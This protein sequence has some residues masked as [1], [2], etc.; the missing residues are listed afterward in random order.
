M[1]F[2]HASV[3]SFESRRA[4]EIAELIR[5]Q[6]GEPFVAPALVE[7]P[8]EHNQNALDFAKRLYAGEF[9]AVIFLTGVGARLLHSVIAARDGEERFLN[10][11]RK[12]V[13]VCRGPKPAAVLREWKVP[14]TILVAEPAT[15]REV[16]TALETRPEK[17]VAIQEY[18]RANPSLVDGLKQQG[19]K[20]TCVAV[21]QWK[22]PDDT[23]LLAQALDGLLGGKFQASLFTTGVQVDHFLE[24]AARRGE[25]ERAVGALNRTFVASIGPDCSESLRACG[26]QPAFEPSHPKMGLLV[27]E[28]AQR[29]SERH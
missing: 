11:L 24:F 22:L 9:E 7:V 16:L 12:V 17:S 3:L 29:F 26:I 1:P 28:A 5:L 15:W 14:L 2:N 25:R 4:A 27:R 18:G 21:Y 6:G 8:L 13:T 19:R 10:A 20:V 23:S